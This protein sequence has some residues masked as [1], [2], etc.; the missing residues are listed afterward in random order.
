[1]LH[2]LNRLLNRLSVV[3][4]EQEIIEKTVIEKKVPEKPKVEQ[5]KTPP[6]IPPTTTDTLPVKEKPSRIPGKGDNS[7]DQ[8]VKTGVQE[9]APSQAG[10][11]PANVARPIPISDAQPI[12][13]QPSS[14]TEG[15]PAADTAPE[16]APSPAVTP[17]GN[18][19]PGQGQGGPVNPNQV[20][21]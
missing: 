7:Q 4:N 16:P 2:L 6:E 1:M 11:S 14:V 21:G 3:I 5:P 15:R 8:L 12:P 19:A 9:S 18:P 13:T 20:P 17:A 10:A